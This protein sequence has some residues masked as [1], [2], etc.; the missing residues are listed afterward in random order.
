MAKSFDRLTR[1]AMR[2]L[3]PGGKIHEHGITFEK[4]ANG[5]G[6]FTVNVMVDGRRIHRV[7]GRESDG[8]TRTQA[9][10]FIA[11]V[12]N[13]AKHDRL[14]LPRG[15]K[16]VLSFRAAC[17]KYLEH[18]VEEGGRDT[19]MKRV[20]LMLHLVP[21]FADMPLSKISSLTLSATSATAGARQR[22]KAIAGERGS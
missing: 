15:R 13:D 4:L 16:L 9:E 2:R 11:K 18:L 5:D 10:E 21:F 12:R 19:K 7:I 20:R 6:V 3:P 8:T 1:P 17:E 14:E 22:S